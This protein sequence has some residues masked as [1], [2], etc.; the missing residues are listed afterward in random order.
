MTSTWD[1]LI[2]NGTVSMTDGA[3][4]VPLT[5]S[6][7]LKGTL[8][9]PKEVTSLGSNA[10]ADCVR[11]T[12]VYIS[13]GVTSIGN[14]AFIDCTGLTNITISESV[15]SIS[16]DAFSNC[17]VKTTNF[18]NNSSCTSPNNWETTL[19]DDYQNA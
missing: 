5:N 6:Q 10:F 9:L 16:E 12:S 4:L 17:Y 2:E 14:Y 7:K 19:C 8:V 3:V 11:L 18:L 1:E 15:T 13:F